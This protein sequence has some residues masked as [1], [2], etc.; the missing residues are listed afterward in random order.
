MDFLNEKGTYIVGKPG[1][2][3]MD[4]EQIISL[5]FDRD[6]RA[7]AETK[8]K[9]GRYCFRIAYNILKS[10]ED[11]EE[12]VSDTYVG[13]WNAIPPHR[14]NVF[15]A[16]LAKIT[17]RLSLKRLRYNTARKR[18]GADEPTLALEELEQCIPAGGAVADEIEAKELGEMIDRFLQTQRSDDRHIFLRRYFYLEKAENIAKAFGYSRSKVYHSLDHTRE[19]LRDYLRKEG[20]FDE[21]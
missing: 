12:V 14:P 10:N 21:E 1:E 5:Y 9:Y 6:E 15:S 4:D 18:G 11:S 8:S 2:K 3:G 7:I 16:F 19:K 20:V 17:R 13:A